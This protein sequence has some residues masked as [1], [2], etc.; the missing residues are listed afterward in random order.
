M[1]KAKHYTISMDPDLMARIDV[2]SN[3]KN[4]N[5][6]A[7]IAHACT[8]YMDALER[9]PDA[10]KQLKDLTEALQALQSIEI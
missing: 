4:G 7:F 10:K 8:E 5:R 1:A 3:I 9:L 2:M 6:S